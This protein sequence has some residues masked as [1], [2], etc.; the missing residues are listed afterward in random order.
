M[1]FIDDVSRRRL[2]GERAGDLPDIAAGMLQNRNGSP[3]RGGEHR[4]GDLERKAHLRYS[5]LD[6][7]LAIPRKRVGGFASVCPAF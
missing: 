6:A 5:L 3:L 1:R 2:E 4:E 7:L